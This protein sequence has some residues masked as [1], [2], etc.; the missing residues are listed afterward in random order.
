M[1]SP[2]FDDLFL[3]EERIEHLDDGAEGFASEG[4]AISDAEAEGGQRFEKL[5]LILVHQEV[6]IVLSHDFIGDGFDGRGS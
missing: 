1:E 5:G 6:S 2:P 4:K 3:P